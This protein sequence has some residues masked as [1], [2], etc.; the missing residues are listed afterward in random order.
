MTFIKSK[1]RFSFLLAGAMVAASLW[2]GL[3]AFAQGTQVYKARLSVVP[4]ANSAARANIDESATVFAAASATATLTGT[5]L[6]ITGTFEGF[7]SPASI[8]QLRSGPAMGVRGPVLFDLTVTK[9]TKGT[10]S[11]TLDLTQAQVDLLKNSRLYI[12]IHNENTPEGALWGW[13]QK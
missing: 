7:K 9:A 1:E 6:A 2:A 8:A 12:Q 10:I 5:R 4:V 3:S 13:F 11:G